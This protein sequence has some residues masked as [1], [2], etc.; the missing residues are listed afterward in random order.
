MNKGFLHSM[1]FLAL[2]T[3][4][5]LWPG[6][7][8]RDNNGTCGIFPEVRPPH[9]TANLFSVNQLLAVPVPVPLQ[10]VQSKDL[11]TARFQRR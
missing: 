11:V 6:V 7:L 5:Q 1:Q 4:N 10:S 2:L 8:R 3:P 9:A